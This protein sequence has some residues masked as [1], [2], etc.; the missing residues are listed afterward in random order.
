MKGRNQSAWLSIED[1]T[2]IK[3]HA[4]TAAAPQPTNRPPGSWIN[5]Y[6]LPQFI[7]LVNGLQGVGI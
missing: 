6:Y 4:R 3:V 7:S 1:G 2:K 5:N